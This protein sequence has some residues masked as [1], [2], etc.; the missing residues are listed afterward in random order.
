MVIQY[1]YCKGVTTQMKVLSIGGVHIVA[2]QNSGFRR[3]YI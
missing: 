1:R 3:F 2:E